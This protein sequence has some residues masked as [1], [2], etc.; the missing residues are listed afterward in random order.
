MFAFGVVVA[1]LVLFP[2]IYVV[3]MFVY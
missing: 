3:L 1:V 2:T